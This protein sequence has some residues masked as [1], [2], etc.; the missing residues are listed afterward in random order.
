MI[1]KVVPRILRHQFFWATMVHAC[2]I[3]WIVEKVNLSREKLLAY[4]LVH[5]GDGQ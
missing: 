1:G 3:H 4:S 2:S 5:E